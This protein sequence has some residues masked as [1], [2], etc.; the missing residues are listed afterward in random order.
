MLAAPLLS[1]FVLLG[2]MGGPATA[3]APPAEQVPN[4]AILA[5]LARIEKGMQS[6]RYQHVAQVVPAKGIYR[7]DCSIMAGWILKKATPRARQVLRAKPLARDFYDTIARS[8]LHGQRSHWTRV[9]G[10]RAIEPGDV[11]AWRKP[12]IF[13]DRNNTGHVG[14][15][16]G[17]PWQHPQYPAIWLARIADA[18]RELHEHDSRPVGGEGG[19][20]TAVIAFL[21]DDRG[22][23]VAYG[24]YGEAQEAETYVP[25]HIVFGRALR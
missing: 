2:Q 5:E 19:F 14:F 18:T 21:F 15:V 4:R 12:E 22:E 3:V 9:L 8:P 24:W 7:W 10:P 1:A 20:G 25:T 17:K 13:K 11:F 6:T 23:A 16:V